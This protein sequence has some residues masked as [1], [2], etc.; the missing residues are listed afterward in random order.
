[1]DGLINVD[2]MR[3]SVYVCISGWKVDLLGVFLI[4]AYAIIQIS[5]NGHIMWTNF[6]HIFCH[7]GSG[8][9]W[10]IEDNWAVDR[11]THCRAVWLDS[12]DV[13]RRCLG[14]GHGIRW[15]LMQLPQCRV[16]HSHSK[17]LH[18]YI[19]RWAL[20]L[21]HE[22]CDFWHEG[23]CIEEAVQDAPLC[24]WHRSPGEASQGTSRYKEIGL[25]QEAKVR[26]LQLHR[27][28][29]GTPLIVKLLSL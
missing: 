21:S 6:S 5:K 1:M 26:K 8:S 24:L 10:D 2:G 11:K 18:C 25:S 9:D 27:C 13:H 20:P 29:R 14:T 16:I 28:R 17:H 19:C 4:R 23:H 15:G 22:T 3:F 7:P 12:G